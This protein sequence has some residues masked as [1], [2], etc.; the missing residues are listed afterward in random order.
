[1][2]QQRKNNAQNDQ[3]NQK[4]VPRG[5]ITIQKARTQDKPLDKCQYRFFLS[6]SPYCSVVLSIVL[7]CSVCQLRMNGKLVHCSYYTQASTCIIPLPS[8]RH[9]AIYSIGSVGWWG[10]N[11]RIFKA[12]YYDC[13]SHLC[14]GPWAEPSSVGRYLKAKDTVA[15][16]KNLVVCPSYYRRGTAFLVI[17]YTG[18]TSPYNTEHNTEILYSLPI[19]NLVKSVYTLI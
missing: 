18:N 3:P 4:G 7:H 9:W 5:E 17:I 13:C 10:V 19:K 12:Q 16:K 8:S 6:S 15:E 1:M 11:T 2:P 14:Q